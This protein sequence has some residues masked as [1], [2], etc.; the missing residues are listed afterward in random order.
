MQLVL[1]SWGNELV[2]KTKVIIL[3]FAK[4]AEIT[5]FVLIGAYNI[6]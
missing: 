4:N 2:T 6:L 5:K 1:L 3:F